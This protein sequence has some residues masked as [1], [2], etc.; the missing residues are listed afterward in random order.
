MFVLYRTYEKRQIIMILIYTTGWDH[1]RPMYIIVGQ[2]N[3]LYNTYV[4]QY[5]YKQIHFNG[6]QSLYH[7]Q[8]ARHTTTYGTE[9]GT[10][11]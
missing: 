3:A 10:D 6:I 7:A 1:P 11:C 8:H 4:Y 2:V 9:Y 5:T